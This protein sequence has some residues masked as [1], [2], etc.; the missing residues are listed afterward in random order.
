MNINKTTT[1]YQLAE[2]EALRS[3]PSGLRDT[4]SPYCMMER[5]TT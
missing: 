4:D 1:K 2:G 3:A 5:P